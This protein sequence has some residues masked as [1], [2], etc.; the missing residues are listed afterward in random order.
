MSD[1]TPAEQELGKKLILERISEAYGRM[2]LL[3]GLFHA[4][5]HPGNLM[6]LPQARIGM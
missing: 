3:E 2:I 6:V 4:D 5:C 1:R